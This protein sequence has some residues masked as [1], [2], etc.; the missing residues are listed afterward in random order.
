M[1]FYNIRELK[2]HIRDGLRRRKLK[3]LTSLFEQIAVMPYKAPSKAFATIKMRAWKLPSR[4]NG[5]VLTKNGKG[6]KWKKVWASLSIFL[7]LTSQGRNCKGI[8][9]LLKPLSFFLMP[10]EVKL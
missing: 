4:G 8:W 5:W 9:L 10:L 7:S 3:F 6:R 1:V 2:N